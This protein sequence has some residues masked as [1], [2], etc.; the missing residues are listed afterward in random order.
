MTLDLTHSNV[1]TTMNA[2][3]LFDDI[4]KKCCILWEIALLSKLKEI[5]T[6]SSE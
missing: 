3:A 2:F 4:F 5:F 1:N 6:I